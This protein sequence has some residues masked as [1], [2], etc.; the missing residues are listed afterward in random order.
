MRASRLLAILMLLQSRGRLSAQALAAA[1]EVSVRTIYRDVDGLSAAGIP[2][3]ALTGR[4]GGVCLR[5]GW[6]TQLTGLTAPEARAVFFTGLPGPAAQLGMREALGLAQLKLLAALPLDAR[7]DAQRAAQ[8]FHL[9]PADWF[10]QA[11]PAPLLQAVAQAV[12]EG[13]RIAVRYQ[14]WQRTAEHVLEPLGLVLKA[15][16][17]YLAARRAATGLDGVTPRGRGDRTAARRDEPAVWRLAAIETLQPLAETFVPPARFQLAA[18]WREATTRFESGVYTAHAV[19]RLD[20]RGFERLCRF[21]PQVRRAAEDSAEPA[22]PD[23]FVRVTV[24]IESIEH[25]AREM[26]SLGEHVYVDEPAPLRQR[27]AQS[28]RAMLEHLGG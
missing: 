3:Y 15:G 9:D 5:E 7:A 22:A 10:T 17:W 4:H 1:L 27:L 28:A 26:L 25:A 23:G 13:R 18:W 11:E 16:S 12:W 19:L 20:E 14:S 8:R 24:P 21:S 2:V 6:R